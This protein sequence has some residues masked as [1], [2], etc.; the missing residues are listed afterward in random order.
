ME[1][2]T[3]NR[4]LEQRMVRY[5]KYAKK[6]NKYN[7]LT[8]HFITPGIRPTNFIEFRGPLHFFKEIKNGDKTMQTAEKQQVK[9]K[10]NLDEIKSGNPRHKL[11]N[12]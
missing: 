11:Q 10:S 9:L 12:Q 5:G 8:Y 1:E 2:K 6:K 7:N 3:F 4:L